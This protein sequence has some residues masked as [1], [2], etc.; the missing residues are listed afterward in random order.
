MR[1]ELWLLDTL[2]RRPDRP[3]RY[4]RATGWEDTTAPSR[5]HAAERAWRVCALAPH[6]LDADEQ[7]W[8]TTWDAAARG[9]GFGIGDICVVD[10]EPL[11]CTAQG[12]VPTTMPE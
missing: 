12:F 2:A 10:G 1:V 9:F 3:A 11:L 6:V 8:R 7:V 5:T 4:R